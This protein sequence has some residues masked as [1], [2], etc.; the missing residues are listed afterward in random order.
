MAIKCGVSN[1][2]LFYPLLKSLKEKPLCV[3]FAVS[4]NR[5]G[6]TH[7]DMRESKK[8]HRRW[9]IAES[10]AGCV[11]INPANENMLVTSHLNRDMRIWDVRKLTKI[12]SVKSDYYTSYEKACVASYE[13]GK[14]VT[15][16]YFDP[17]G[18]NL[19]STCYDDKIRGKCDL[20]DHWRQIC[21]IFVLP[22]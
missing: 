2:S 19:L 9:K 22:E 16:A 15:S 3:F 7:A 12:D 18:R 21:L 5:G 13:H 8:Q 10:K 6:L 17:S 4:D 20:S 1:I 14:A 11:A